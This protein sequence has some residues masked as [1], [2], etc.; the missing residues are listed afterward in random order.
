MSR[1]S[2]V[3]LAVLAAIH[4]MPDGRILRVEKLAGSTR[5]LDRLLR[6]TPDHKLLGLRGPVVS[7]GQSPLDSILGSFSPPMIS[8]GAESG[9]IGAIGNWPDGSPI[10]AHELSAAG[11]AKAAKHSSA[12]TI[13]ID[14]IENGMNGLKNDVA[15]VH[16]T[17]NSMNSQIAAALAAGQHQPHHNRN[18]HPAGTQEHFNHEAMMRKKAEIYASNTAVD[19]PAKVTQ[20]RVWEFPIGTGYTTGLLGGSQVTLAAQPQTKFQ[21]Q[22]LT[23]DAFQT[24]SNANTTNGYQGNGVLDL[25]VGQ[26]SQFNVTGINGAVIPLSR[27]QPTMF[28][29]NLD[30][31]VAETS[32]YIFIIVVSGNPSTVT[33]FI[34]FSA[35]GRSIAT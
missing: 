25:K 32:Q 26:R 34:N 5:S 28:D 35:K 11:A 2:T 3:G 14:N 24:G 19:E 27:Y 13:R 10:M 33:N 4:H 18:P 6:D 12:A 16:A 30:C 22:R 29:G 17:L 31:E 15:G 23:A 21:L 20:S 8:G 1:L 9:A 7:V